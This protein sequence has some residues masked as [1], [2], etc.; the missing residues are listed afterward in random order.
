[1]VIG[2][3]QND[4]PGCIVITVTDHGMFRNSD[5][6]DASRIDFRLIIFKS[7]CSPGIVRC[8]GCG[9]HLIQ[10]IARLFQIEFQPVFD[11]NI[12]RGNRFAGAAGSDRLLPVGIFDACQGGIRVEGSGQ[13]AVVAPVLVGSEVVGDTVPFRRVQRDGIPH[14]G[15]GQFRFRGCFIKMR[16]MFPGCDGRPHDGVK[17]VHIVFIAVQPP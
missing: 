3:I 14:I 5:D 16:D 17:R 8:M 1:M 13:I 15:I 7:E 4:F 11:I 2:V 9:F 10:L 12:F 6:D